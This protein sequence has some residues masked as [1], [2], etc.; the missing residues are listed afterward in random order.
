MIQPYAIINSF[1]LVLN[2]VLW[3]GVSPFN[4]GGGVTLVATGGNPNAQIG[5]TYISGV[6]TPSTV[7]APQGIVY[8][9]IPTSG[10]TVV[11]PNAPQPQNILYV[12]MEPA[13]ALASLA[14]DMPPAPI[15]G[16]QVILYSTRSVTALTCVPEGGQV[17]N[18]GPSSLTALVPATLTFSAQYSAWFSL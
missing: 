4:P 10:S 11:L 18:N 13:A 17:V 1:G 3:D 14:I 8:L 9:T 2:I 16:C 15:D 12:I 7:V 6:W 5:G